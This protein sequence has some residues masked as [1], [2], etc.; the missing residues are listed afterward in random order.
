MCVTTTYIADKNHK[1]LSFIMTS[2]IDN[3]FTWDYMLYIPSRNNRKDTIEMPVYDTNMM[4]YAE[5]QVCN[6]QN[7]YSVMNFLFEFSESSTIFNSTTPLNISKK[8]KR[9]VCTKCKY[10]HVKAS[11]NNYMCRKCCTDTGKQCP[12]HHPSTKF[13]RGG[14]RVYE[15]WMATQMR[16]QV[17]E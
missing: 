17:S 2:V 14:R 13:Q 12:E 15:R 6:S 11:C 8:D 3:K 5:P 9:R 1:P 16:T 10:N 4:N 7:L